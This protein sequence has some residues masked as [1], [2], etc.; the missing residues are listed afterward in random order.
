MPNTIEWNE[1]NKITRI[2]AR[3][4][5]AMPMKVAEWAEAAPK[6]QKNKKPKRGWEEVKALAALMGVVATHDKLVYHNG[7]SVIEDGCVYCY[8]SS[9][10]ANNA[11][12]ALLSLQKNRLAKLSDEQLYAMADSAKADII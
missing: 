1:F 4:K 7:R 10:S 11:Y 3:Y 2:D 5:G 12:D 9:K 6:T 8:K